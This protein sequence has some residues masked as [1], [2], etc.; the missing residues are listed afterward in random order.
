MR[1]LKLELRQD[2]ATSTQLDRQIAVSRNRVR[3]ALLSAQDAQLLRD[4]FEAD[5]RN[6]VT[7]RLF[8]NG[9]SP[10]YVPG[11]ECPACEEAERIVDELG[12]LSDLISVEKHNF[13]SDSETAIAAGVDRIPAIVVGSDNVDGLLFFGSPSGHEFTTLV[14]TVK[15]VG[16]GEC[17]LTEESRDVLAAL[18]LAID[19]KVFVTPT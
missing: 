16:R 2:R 11:R 6:D 1:E 5:L 4:G 7:L 17:G 18:D 12:G 9:S 8:G 19:L 13:F 3:V 14:E 10:L 15:T